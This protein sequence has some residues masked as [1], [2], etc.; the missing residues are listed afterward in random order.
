MQPGRGEERRCG[1]SLTAIN[2]NGT[3]GALLGSRSY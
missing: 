2:Q 3:R 1:V